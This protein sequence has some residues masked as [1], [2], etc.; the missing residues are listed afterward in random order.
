[1]QEDIDDSDSEYGFSTARDVLPTVEP[2][3]P[4]WLQITNNHPY[5]YFTFTPYIVPYDTSNDTPINAFH[6]HSHTST[7]PLRVSLPI[8]IFLPPVFTTRST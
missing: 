1:M 4:N 3:T 8:G 7:A 6:Q 5:P 2:Q